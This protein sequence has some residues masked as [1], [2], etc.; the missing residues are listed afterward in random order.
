MSETQ[1]PQIPK[2]EIEKSVESLQKQLNEEQIV[3]W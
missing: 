3:N 1:A 2:E